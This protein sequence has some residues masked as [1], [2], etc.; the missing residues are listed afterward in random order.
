MVGGV[1]AEDAE[2]GDD[3]DLGELVDFAGDAGGFGELGVDDVDFVLFRPCGEA[4][5]DEEGVEGDVGDLDAL[6]RVGVL[7]DAFVFDGDDDFVA[8]VDEG[9]AEGEDGA[10]GAGEV[11]GVE[12]LEDFHSGGSGRPWAVE[13]QWRK[14]TAV[15]VPA[16]SE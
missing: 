10:F 8:G 7:E 13:S 1:V 4:A 16:T 15:E 2:V 11:A 3:G 12:D 5:G 6:A 9:F 14:R